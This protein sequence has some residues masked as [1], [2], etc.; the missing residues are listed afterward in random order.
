MTKKQKKSS[1]HNSTPIR[2]L[3]HIEKSYLEELDI[4]DQILRVTMTISKNQHGI[5]ADGR[6][7]RAIKIFTRQ[8]L[9]GM[10]LRQ[11]LAVP[12]TTKHPDAE[13]WDTTSVASLSRNL[14]EGYIQLHFYGLETISEEEAELR[15]LIAKLHKNK[16]WKIIHEM[17][18]PYDPILDEFKNGIPEEKE[19]IKKHP[20]TTSLNRDQK[21][22]IIN[23]NDIYKSKADFEKEL[24]VCKNL[25]RDHRH[26]SNLSHPLPF[27]FERINNERGRGIGSDAEIN[28]SIICLMIARKYLAASTV[29]I[30]DLFHD[31]IGL[32]FANQIERIRPL[33]LS[34]FE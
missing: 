28:Y 23:K 24:I 18:N 34:G 33:T 17:T 4:Y 2:P 15:F 19:R 20:F 12:S 22:R 26:L 8:T 14:M 30:A 7:M 27:S 32:K 13:I 3:T 10:S 9:T 5:E 6:G 16:T 25:V 31:S 29:G 1:T 11:I 21:E